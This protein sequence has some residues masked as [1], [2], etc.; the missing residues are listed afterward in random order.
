MENSSDTDL[1]NP[2]KNAKPTALSSWKTLC[3]ILIYFVDVIPRHP[4]LDEEWDELSSQ[5][6]L[7]CLCAITFFSGSADYARLPFLH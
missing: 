2:R 4:R 1:L 6:S 3:A 5:P 7:F